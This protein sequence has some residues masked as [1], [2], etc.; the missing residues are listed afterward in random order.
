MKR[1]LFA[2]ILCIILVTA[3]LC[4]C[5]PQQ[6]DSIHSQDTT[7]PTASGAT[8]LPTAGNGTT[9]T[10]ESTVT[11]T[12]Q[13]TAPPTTAPTEP[14]C[15][16]VSTFEELA[17]LAA[18]NTLQSGDMIHIIGDMQLPENVIFTI[19]VS[20]SIEALVICTYPIVIETQESGTLEILVSEGVDTSALEIMLDAPNCDVWWLSGQ[21]Y[22]TEEQAAEMTNVASYNGVDLRAEFGLG[23]TGLNEILSFSLDPADN[24]GLESALNYQIEGN[25]VYLAV[26]YLTSD[27]VLEN[28]RVQITTTEGEMV[29]EELDLLAGSRYYTT[30][31]IRGNQRTYKIVTERITYNLPVFYIEIEN[32]EEVTSREEYLNATLR[33]DT[34]NAVGDFPGLETTQIQIRG[35]GHYSWNFDKKPYK[36]RFDKKTSVLGFS[37]SK[38][39]TLIANYVDRS[40]IQNFVALEMGKVM[41]NIPYHSTQYPVDVFVN[42]TYRGVYTFGEQLE[43]KKERINLEESYTDPNTDYLLEVGGSDE[44][45]VY[46]R[47][48]FHAGTLRHIA[49]KHPET[50]QLQQAQ[51]DYLIDYVKKADEAVRTLTNY[52]DYIDVDSLIDWVIIHELTYN[53]DC[54]FRRSCYLI[55]EKDGKLKMGPIWDFDLAFGSHYRYLS[56]D[57][58]TVGSEGG[59]VGITW[60]NYLKDDPAFMARFTAR[61]NEVKE[62]LLQTALTS[63]DTMGA[64]VAPSAEMNFEVWDILGIWIPS[65]PEYHNQYDTYEKMVQR[66]RNFI[67]NRY[68]WLDGQLNGV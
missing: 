57:W 46:G 37:A 48:Y 17:A 7:M 63:V 18:E 23:G 33:I 28:A 42:G 60:M 4:G 30:S 22:E 68:N 59:Y 14:T 11:P 13:T 61:W 35:R 64:L 47:D 65:Q 5:A 19:P 15:I 21:I 40:L 52:E 49:I 43:A 27:T 26:S 24:A 34:E 16:E 10:T 25:V 3:C 54:S 31:D 58:A 8:T 6:L 20:L 29:T 55:K 9:P 53:L 45:D 67:I 1:T 32:G 56:G 41:D 50:E 39:W 62:Q 36:I 12:T 66:L 2:R 44:G 51:L 38:N